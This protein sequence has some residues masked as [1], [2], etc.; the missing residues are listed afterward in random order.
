MG[1]REPPMGAEELPMGAGEK[2][3]LY[4]NDNYCVCFT[5][6]FPDEVVTEETPNFSH[7]QLSERRT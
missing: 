1:A 5:Y 7:G 6:I 3:R 2:N 4:N